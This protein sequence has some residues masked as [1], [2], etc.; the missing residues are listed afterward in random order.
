MGATGG[1]VLS[2]R[3][4][5][6][7]ASAIALLA[8]SCRSVVPAPQPKGLSSVAVGGCF[9]EEILAPRCGG[10]ELHPDEERSPPLVTI[11]H[12]C[13]E[14][15]HCDERPEGKCLILTDIDPCRASRRVC[16]Y[17]GDSCYPPARCPAGQDCYLQ[18]ELGVCSEPP[19]PNP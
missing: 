7:I 10:A 9:E 17:P 4:L 1:P 15:R 18:G 5:I 12:R 11:C 8:L 13:L 2:S 16:L 14:D 3:R 19:A 6:R